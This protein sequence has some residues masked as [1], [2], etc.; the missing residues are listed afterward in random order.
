MLKLWGH[1][2]RCR[3]LVMTMLIRDEEEILERNIRYHAAMG[4]DGFIVTSHRSTDGSVGILK[5]LQD[6]GLV[7][8][9]IEVDEPE[10]RQS[11]WV[12]DMVNRAA[13]K[14]GAD[15]VMHADADEFYYSRQLDLKESINRNC[16]ANVL[17]VDSIF[18]MPDDSEEFLR[19]PWFITRPM[20]GFEA[21]ALGVANDPNFAAFI[22]SRNCTKVIHSTSGFV[23]IAM[24]N[25]DVTMRRVRKVHCADIRLYHYHVRNYR[26]F[27]AKILRYAESAPLMPG[28]QGA[29]MKTYLELYRKGELRAFYDRKFSGHTRDFLVENGVVARDPSVMMFMRREGLL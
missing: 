23:R 17:W 29:H 3:K 16:C 9:T 26:G 22:G 25:H 5:R 4:V 1:E 6:E 13:R 15:W 7:L 12:G 8:E 10:Y 11:A 20:T 19:C 28:R 14:H 2:G 27:E 18:S 24:G 21:E